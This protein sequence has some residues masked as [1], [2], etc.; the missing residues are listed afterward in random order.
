M[1][2]LSWC[3]VLAETKT[4]GRDMGLF[5]FLLLRQPSKFI[6]AFMND[7]PQFI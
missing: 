4:L 3:K 1:C 6:T 7:L 5:S 2:Y